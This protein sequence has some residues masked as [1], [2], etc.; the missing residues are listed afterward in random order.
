MYLGI[1]SIVIYASIEI[2]KK[3]HKN[4]QKIHLNNTNLN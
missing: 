4:S 2:I 3:Y 1:E